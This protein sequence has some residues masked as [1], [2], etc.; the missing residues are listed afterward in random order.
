[1]AFF[2]GT[3]MLLGVVTHC[4]A[5]KNPQYAVFLRCQL[6]S[7]LS[8]PPAIPTTPIVAYATDDAAT[9]A[10]I[11]DFDAMAP[12][13]V[14][15]IPLTSRQMWRRSIARNIAAQNY[16]RRDALLWFTDCDYLFGPG[17][18]HAAYTEWEK[19]NKPAMIW[20][21]YVLANN[22]KAAVDRMVA[23]YLRQPT[24]GMLLPQIDY[25]TPTKVTRAIGGLQIVCGDYARTRG[26]VPYGRWQRE[27][28]V[29]FPNFRDDVAFRR[30]LERTHSCVTVT[31]LP[32][33]L[34][35]RHT[36]VGYGA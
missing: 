18:I 14:H 15:T 8:D 27:P 36:E 30:D 24:H 12:G 13:W 7:L 33:L 17:C 35:L 31:K 25:I 4:W 10:V 20:P 32:G 22:D 6:S 11:A 21:Y 28:N 34:R 9:A 19:A 29:P 5:V 1:M 16:G 26:Y 2:I 3:I 23:D